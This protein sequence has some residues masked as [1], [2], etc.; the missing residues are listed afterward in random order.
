[1]I[2]PPALHRQARHIV[3]VL[4]RHGHQ[5][6]WVGGCVRDRLL[7]REPADYDVATS[8]SVEAVRALFPHTV[9]VGASFG[10]V[11]VIE[12]GVPFQVA[13]FRGKTLEEDAAHRDFTVGALFFDPET[14]RVLDPVGGLE[15]LR[16]RRIRAVGDPASRFQEDPLRPLRAVRLAAT[17]GFSIEARTL[18]AVQR[19]ASL[20]T[21]ASPERIRDELIRI[22]T[23]PDPSRGLSLLSETG[24]LAHLLPEVEAL[25]GVPQPSRYHPEGDV[26]EHTRRALAF[27]DRPS[28]TLAFATLLHDVGKPE[29]L[30]R[31]PGGRIRFL[32][33]ETR[34]AETARRLLE[35]L[36][37]PRKE[38]ARVAACIE[39]HLR[40]ARARQMRPGKL[41][42]LL[43]RETFEDELALLRADTLAKGGDLEAWEY[44]RERA[45]ALTAEQ[46]RPPPLLRG[47]DLL[48]LGIPPGPRI[49]RLLREVEAL[50]LEGRLKTREEALAHVRRRMDAP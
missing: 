35:R 31:D 16:L 24:L 30:A 9:P 40:L 21:R 17:L 10:V 42:R 23:G 45:R 7:G 43:R 25:K 14:G 39:N 11:L 29:T 5:A 36:R 41:K 26:F 18:A 48:A 34:G 3:R 8:A 47:K 20:P 13:T 32:G 22:F 44:L 19:F 33:H 6:Y 12:E 38:A 4:R 28:V 27:L 2:H 37:F 49:G 15:D 46:L 1:M 50:Q